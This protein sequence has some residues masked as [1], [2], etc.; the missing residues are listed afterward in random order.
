M[1]KCHKDEYMDSLIG[2]KVTI[3]FKDG[4]DETGI[5]AYPDFGIGYML[6]SSKAFDIRFFK[7]HVKCIKVLP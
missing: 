3:T 7:S 5:L 2:R 1:D 4:S 6:K